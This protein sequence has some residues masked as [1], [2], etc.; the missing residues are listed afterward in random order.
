MLRATPVLAQLKPSE[1]F[2]S[3]MKSIRRAPRGA[4]LSYYTE[5]LTRELNYEEFKE[6][7]RRRLKLLRQLESSPSNAPISSIK[8]LEEDLKDHACLRLVCCQTRWLSN[9]F[10]NAEAL[11]FTARVGR[12]EPAA[13][14]FFLAKVWPR[15][16]LSERL[17]EQASSPAQHGAPQYCIG[18]DTRFSTSHRS[19]TSFK[20]DFS[21][22]FS[23]CSDIL[24]KRTQVPVRGFFRM[25]SAV[26]KSFLIAE[27]RSHLTEQVNR[28]YEKLIMEPDE[29]INNLFKE[30]FAENKPADASAFKGTLDNEKSFPLCIR[31]IVEHLKTNRHLKYADRQ[32]LC[33][34]F[35][36]IGVPVNETIDYFRKHFLVNADKFNREYIYSLRHNYGLEGKR[37]NYTSYTCLKLVGLVSE[38]NSFGCPFV[39]NAEFVKKHSDIEDLGQDVFKSCSRVG[40]S[41]AGREL[42]GTFTTPAE[43]FRLV[44][45][46]LHGEHAESSNV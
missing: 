33:L 34:F 5:L 3:L 11:L 2:S 7:A 6:C 31:G 44:E 37:A 21:V 22:H 8:S 18:K 15:L 20:W 12:D 32:T 29:R 10:V 30:L 26:L 14:Q 27:F 4:E 23:K 9:W 16:N 19:G 43:Y 42:P 24:A 45:K 39:K 17:P 46:A 35:K 38:P 36:D 40:A 1:K 41:V 13:Q 25:D 28:L